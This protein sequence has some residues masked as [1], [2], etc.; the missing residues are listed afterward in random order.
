MKIG[1]NSHIA[2][3]VV[4]EQPNNIVIGNNVK[5]KEGVVLRPE[6]GFIYI[7]NNV[8]INHYTVMHGKGGIEIGDWSIIAP[9]CQLYAQNHRF[10]SFDVPITKQPNVGNGITLMGDNWLG[11]GAIITDGVNLGKG[12]VVGAGSVVTKSFPMAVVACGNPARIIKHRSDLGAWSFENEERCSVEGTPDKYWAYINKRVTFAKSFVKPESSVLDIGCGEGY[13][14]SQLKKYG[15][16]KLTGIDY[17]EEALSKARAYCEG[18]NFIHSSCTNIKIKKS[19]FDVVFIFEILEHL[20]RR[21]T[22]L[23]IK[24]ALRVLKVGGVLVGSTPIR[25]TPTSQPKTYSHIHEYNKPE[26]TKMFNACGIL[27]HIESNGFFKGTK[28]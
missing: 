16:S 26:L 2:K 22:V 23:C 20:T 3:N 11:G 12:T 24:E 15:V 7:G 9:H 5:I 13:L 25:K 17:S 18:F 28:I 27:V 10:G 21:Q 8:V 1:K 14:C 19:F 6:T 4:I